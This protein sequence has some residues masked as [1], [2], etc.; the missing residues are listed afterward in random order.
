MTE[1]N[2]RCALQ[3]SQPWHHYDIIWTRRIRDE[4]QM[5]IYAVFSTFAQLSWKL[6][7]LRL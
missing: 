2:E 7:A 4:S 1:T 5:Y 3:Q 6:P